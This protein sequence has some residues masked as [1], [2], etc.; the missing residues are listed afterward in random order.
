MHIPKRL[1]KV[2]RN[3]RVKVKHN[4]FTDVNAIPEALC[5]KVLFVIAID[6]SG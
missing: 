1:E 4:T 2:I 5:G 3:T 6:E